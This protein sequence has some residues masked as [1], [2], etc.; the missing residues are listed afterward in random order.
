MSDQAILVKEPTVTPRPPITVLLVDDQAMIGAAVKRMLEGEPDVTLHFIST[1]LEAVEKARAL[2]PTVILQDLV[3]PGVEGLDLVTDFRHDSF[4]AEIP[5]IVLSSKEE[6]KIKAEAF[7][8]GANDYL[9]KL[10]DR[11]ELLARIR[12]HSAGYIAAQERN[13]AFYALEASQ[14]ALATELQ[15]AAEYVRSLLPAPLESPRA[16]A[17]WRFVP[18]TA[19]GGDAFGYFPIDDEHF[20]CF[21]LDVCGH[22]VGAALLS[23]SAMNTIRNESLPGVDFRDPTAVLEALNEAF[24]ME[25]HNNMYFTI[26]YGVF[27]RSTRRLAYASGGHPPALLAAPAAPLTQLRTRGMIIGGMPGVNFPSESCIIPEDSWLYVFSD[28]TYE[29]TRPDLPMMDLPDLIEIIQPLDPA[30][31]TKL[32][33][34]VEAIQNAHGSPQFEDDFSLLALCFD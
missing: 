9:V 3:M 19:L 14:K 32:D 23:V 26:W 7:A 10:P 12:Y 5:L 18:S 34:V 29:V 11:V 4:T 30:D 1:P 33:K 13:A 16:R 21:L 31:P 25:K 15:E 2:R 28:G 20:A 17:E 8:R 6:P 24:A 27:A 22:G